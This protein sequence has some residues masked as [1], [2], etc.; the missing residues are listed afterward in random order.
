MEE[1]T[2][3]LIKILLV[4]IIL[5]A[6]SVAPFI[7]EKLISKENLVV[8]TEKL[9]VSASEG[10]EYIWVPEVKG[11]LKSLKITGNIAGGEPVKIYLI[12][13]TRQYLILDSSQLT[14]LRREL[15]AVELKADS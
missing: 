12:G 14:A 15:S 6:L 9:G 8:Q 11:T 13:K 2:Y 5:V 10:A 3:T 7:G 1:H 4:L